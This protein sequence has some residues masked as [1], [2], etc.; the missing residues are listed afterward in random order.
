MDDTVQD[1][2]PS[3]DR[4][5][6]IY[7]KIR[8]KRDATRHEWEDKD[9]ALEVQMKLIEQEL[10]ELC[11]TLNANSISTNHGTVVRSVK[12][13]YW[14]N[15]WDSMYHLIK[16]NDAFALLEKRIHQTHMKEFLQENP[17][18]LPAGLNVENEFTVIVRRKKEE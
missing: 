5:A 18:L 16:E 1:E 17:A 14:T 6:Q 12:S 3:V 7:I 4:L 11:K 10:L 15:D 9:K 8:D 13:R 2:K